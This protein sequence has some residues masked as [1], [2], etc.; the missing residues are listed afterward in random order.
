MQARAQQ[1]LNNLLDVSVEGR[2]LAQPVSGTF[3]RSFGSELG[4]WILPD[5]RVGSGYNFVQVNRRNDFEFADSGNFKQGFYLT[6]TTKISNLFDL[7]GTSKNGLENH[8]TK[9]TPD[10]SEKIADNKPDKQ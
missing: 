8:R 9:E 3:R 10:A 6:L 5:L 4:F 1:R 7:F 2:W